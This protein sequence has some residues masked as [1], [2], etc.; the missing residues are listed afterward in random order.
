MSRCWTETRK[1]A[2]EDTDLDAALYLHVEYDDKGQPTNAWISTP[3]KFENKTIDLLLAAVNFA[4]ADL[5]APVDL[6]DILSAQDTVS[7]GGAA[8]LQPTDFKVGETPI[9]DLLKEPDS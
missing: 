9:D 6:S 7:G 2:A 4:L 3:G 1:I 5:M 8:R